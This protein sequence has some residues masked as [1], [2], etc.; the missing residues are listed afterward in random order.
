VVAKQ[1]RSPARKILATWSPLS[2]KKPGPHRNSMNSSTAQG[3][4]GKSHQRAAQPV[5]RSMSTESLRSNQLRLYFSSL[6]Y[7]LVEALRRVG[8]A[9][10]NGQSI[11]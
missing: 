4:D 9:E 11:R 1:N 5:Q 6:A 3:R 8:L 2:T 7:V 10:R